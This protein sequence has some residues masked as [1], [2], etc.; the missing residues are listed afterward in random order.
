MNNFEV[1]VMQETARGQLRFEYI[2]LGV[3]TMTLWVLIAAVAYIAYR[4]V[5][6]DSK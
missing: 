6:S 4:V 5:K 2:E 1:M 3:V